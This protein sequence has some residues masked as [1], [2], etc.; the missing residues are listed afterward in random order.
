[1]VGIIR[2]YGKSRPFARFCSPR[3]VVLSGLP[4]GGEHG[5]VPADPVHEHTVFE[6]DD[7][8]SPS[9]HP[10]AEQI[11]KA[12]LLADDAARRGRGDTKDISRPARVDVGSGRSE[13][14]PV[15]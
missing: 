15:L 12:T 11:G 13:S 14:I 8:V 4:P 2:P 5:D 1:M 6:E 10:R 3:A 9:R 7:L